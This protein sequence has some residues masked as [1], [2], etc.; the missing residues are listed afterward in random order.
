MNHFK[1]IATLAGIVFSACAFGQPQAPAFQQAVSRQLHSDF[2]TAGN[3]RAFAMQART[4]PS[5][6][7]LFYAR[8]VANI[9]GRDFGVIGAYGQQAVAKT[10]RTTGTVPPYQVRLMNELARRCDGF[11]AGEVDAI[12]AESSRREAEDPLLS[13]VR[14]IRNATK[15]GTP[16]EQLRAAVLKGLEVDDPLFWTENRLHNAVAQADP[17]ARKVLGIYVGGT[18]YS[19]RDGIRHL[20]ASTALD[21]GFCKPNLPCSFDDELLAL[22]A[23]GAA[24]AEDREQQAKN[25]YLANGGSA[26][27]WPRVLAMARQVRAAIE[28]RDVSYF[29]R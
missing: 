4:R 12:L 29:V 6:G 21:L 11:V 2:A 15:S 28:R 23:T 25:Y 8:Y 5:E 7:G 16:R 9:C 10:V 1:L 17:G 22:C 13:L 20:E 19:D 3:L 14:E 27:A 24:C 26:N 18:V